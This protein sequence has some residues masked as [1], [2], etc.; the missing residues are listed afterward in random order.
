[1]ESFFATVKKE[2]ADP[3]PRVMLGRRDADRKTLWISRVVTECPFS[4][5]APTAQ[6]TSCSA[7]TGDPVDALETIATGGTLLRY[8]GDANEYIYNWKTPSAG[9]YALF[10]V[11]DTGQVF[12]AY[13]NL[14]K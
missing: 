9:G 11:L 1:M 3:T 13:F 14:A 7:F 10:L 6:S 5:T 8:D 12:D 2:E 4:A